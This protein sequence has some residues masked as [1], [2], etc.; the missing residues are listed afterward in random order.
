[1][2][3]RLSVGDKQFVLLKVLSTRT[4]ASM[5]HHHHH[6]YHHRYFRVA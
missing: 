1:M 2:V 4:Y 6:H 5:C 3:E